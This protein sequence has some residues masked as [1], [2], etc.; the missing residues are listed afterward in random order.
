MIDRVSYQV[1]LYVVASM[2]LF[3]LANQA[4]AMD[5]SQAGPGLPGEA[6]LIKITRFFT[7]PVAFAAS[8]SGIVGGA[9]ALAFGNAMGEFIK[10]V[11]YI[12]GVIGILAFAIQVVTLLFT[13]A[14]VPE[15]GIL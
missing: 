1:I 7:G 15:A 12:T 5:A 11:L 2:A 3:L 10:T 8:V 4:F 13:G 14:V 6:A 9:A